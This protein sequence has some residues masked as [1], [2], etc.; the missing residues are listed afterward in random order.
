MGGETRHRRG[1]M[2]LLWCALVTFGGG[3]VSGGEPP[4]PQPQPR[5]AGE[6]GVMRWVE[7]GEGEAGPVV[8]R[9]R[10]GA[11]PSVVA[12]APPADVGRRVVV[13]GDG[14][15]GGVVEMAGGAEGL[16]G[17]PRFVYVPDVEPQDVRGGARVPEK[18]PEGMA[19]REAELL[20]EAVRRRNAQEIEVP[21]GLGDG[22]E[23][24]GEIEGAALVEALVVMGEDGGD[25]GDV[26]LVIEVGDLGEGVRVVLGE[27]TEGL[28]GG[29]L[30]FFGEQDSPELREAAA[31]LLREALG[32]G[33]VVAEG[34]R[35]GV[36]V[37]RVGG[38]L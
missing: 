2:A 35:D 16:D 24:V 6:S 33:R 27:I 21:M 13:A 29:L 12:S 18:L 4:L 19:L 11:L 5:P 38:V 23:V 1:K 28:R 7:D 25:G 31:V 8:R 3:G 30:P 17:V 22:E 37:F 20:A 36:V 32:V 26:L 14:Q 15:R 9:K 34:E 10:V